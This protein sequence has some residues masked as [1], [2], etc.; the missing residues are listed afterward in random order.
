[1]TTP[2]NHLDDPR[3]QTLA[4]GGEDP[5]ALE[6]VAQCAECA[7]A[8]EA[9]R[10]LFGALDRVEDPEPDAAFAEGVMA[11]I[12][13]ESAV[14]IRPVRGAVLGLIASALAGTALFA[15]WLLGGGSLSSLASD[16][17]QGL[18]GVNKLRVFLGDLLS[19][20]PS[21]AGAAVVF[22]Q[23]LFL[24]SLLYALFRLVK[25]QALPAMEASS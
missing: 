5:G 1:M 25:S 6:H 11:R 20:I 12:A 21:G 10:E 3:L 14:E 8:L 13:A 4:E 22:A 7:E 19:V 15:L 2:T 23:V 16:A 24:G 18:V 17:V 9:Y